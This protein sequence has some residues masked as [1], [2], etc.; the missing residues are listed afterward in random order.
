MICSCCLVE[1]W[2]CAGFGDHVTADDGI[3]DDVW[4]CWLEESRDG[5]SRVSCVGWCDELI[6][7]DEAAIVVE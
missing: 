4:N 3:V 6:C 2:I 7:H 1:W 5:S